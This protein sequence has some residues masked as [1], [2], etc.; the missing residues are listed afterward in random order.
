MMQND[1]VG[2]RDI[3]SA[4]PCECESPKNEIAISNTEPW[5]V[6]KM[7]Q[8]IDKVTSAL[9]S[10]IIQWDQKDDSNHVLLLA[11]GDIGSQVLC[12]VCFPTCRYY[13]SCPV[14]VMAAVKDELK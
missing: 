7:S 6:I 10:D 3:L 2:R 5:R 1:W 13:S 12:A 8:L 4:V 9:D 14:C 11:G